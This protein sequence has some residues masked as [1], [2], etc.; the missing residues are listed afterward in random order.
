MFSNAFNLMKLLRSLAKNDQDLIWIDWDNYVFCRSG[1]DP[2]ANVPFPSGEPSVR[3][4]LKFLDSEG[5]IMV[6][7][8]YCRLTYKAFYYEKIHRSETISFIKRSVL[9]PIFI[10]LATNFLLFLIQ[11]TGARCISLLLQ[12]LQL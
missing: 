3:G 1:S 7:E 12:W 9:V 2:S 6:K 5:Y 8:N 10:T 11:A 4:L